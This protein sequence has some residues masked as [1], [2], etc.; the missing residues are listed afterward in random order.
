MAA[1]APQ[2]PATGTGTDD[3]DAPSSRQ[4][5]TDAE[6]LVAYV[7]SLLLLMSLAIYGQWVVAGVI[8]EKNN[9]VSTDPVDDAAAPPARRQGDRDRAARTRALALVAGLAATLLAAGIFN[10]PA[11][12]GGSLALV[13]PWFALGFALYAV[14]YAAAGALASRSRTPRRPD[15]RSPMRSLPR[16]CRLH[17]TL[18]RHERPCDE[19]PH[20]LPAHRPARATRT[21]C[22]RRRAAWDTPRGRAR[23]RLDLRARPLR[24]PRLR[25]RTPP[26]AA[27]ASTRARLATH[28]PTLTHARPVAERNG[29]LTRHRPAASVVADRPLIAGQVRRKC[30]REVAET[31][32]RSRRLSARASARNALTASSS[33]SD[34]SP[35]SAVSRARLSG[36]R[37]RLRSELDSWITARR[38]RSPS[39]PSS[40]ARLYRGTARSGCPVESNA[41]A[42]SN[43]APALSAGRP[44]TSSSTLARKTSSSRSSIVARSAPI[45][46]RSRSSGPV[47]SSGLPPPGH[48]TGSRR[49][50]RC[51]SRS[52]RRCSREVSSERTATPPRCT[53]TSA[54]RISP[55]S[56]IRRPSAAGVPVQSLTRPSA[57]ATQ[58]VV[59]D[60]GAVGD[61]QL[62]GGVVNVELDLD[63]AGLDLG[64]QQVEDDEAA[65]CVYVELRAVV[66]SPRCLTE[67][68]WA[69][70]SAMG[71]ESTVTAVSFSR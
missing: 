9:R 61:E 27:P 12:L 46:G 31:A 47:R 50:A 2:P 4:E 1:R 18:R 24:R 17:R 62:H 23:P 55:T 40:S 68:P 8:E 67:A 7:G 13:I 16:T 38:R 44:A 41:H 32:S 60:V 34:G 25:P 15:S 58:V 54:F 28:T 56:L 21:Q 64:Q 5:P 39:R 22:A 45:A 3:G 30:G 19:H 66:Q 48:T 52:C 20:G 71:L 57:D 63:L 51:A 36:T 70:I 53:R 59:I 43:A 35:R 10:A 42:R 26:L 65:P 6:T 33:R 11:G 14:A 49:P 29:V 69:R 37:S